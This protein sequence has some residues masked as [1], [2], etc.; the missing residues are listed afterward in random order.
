MAR[1]QSVTAVVSCYNQG[2]SIPETVDS[3]LSQ[4]YGDLRILVIDDGSTDGKTI[5]VLKELEKKDPERIKVHIKENGH[6][7]SVRN[8]GIK[9]CDSEY[10]F[11]SGGYDERMKEGYEDW[12]FYLSVTERGWNISIVKDPLI[13]YRIAESS[14]NTAGY[15]R[16]L[17]IVSYL[18]NKHRA[19]YRK[20]LEA[21]LLEK[22]RA[23]QDKNLELL[24]RIKTRD[25]LPP[26][27]FG[28]GGMAF[29]ISALRAL[30]S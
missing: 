28:D 5:D 7:S 4:T 14:S 11:V 24:D 17:K 22:E 26:V 9:R 8:F 3:L 19:A 16:R 21:V 10:V 2:E 23:L 12:D 15:E 6:V 18:I 27:T 29:A 30:K 25:D 1:E 13:Q 20:H